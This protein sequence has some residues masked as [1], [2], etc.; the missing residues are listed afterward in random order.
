MVA[1]QKQTEQFKITLEKANRLVHILI[2]RNAA[3]PQEIT[4][5]Y[6]LTALVLA[7]SATTASAD[8]APFWIQNVVMEQPAAEV[9][10]QGN[11]DPRDAQ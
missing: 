1:A 5:K 8:I 2:T 11:T 3:N 9:P 6:A 7:V 10:T 4:M